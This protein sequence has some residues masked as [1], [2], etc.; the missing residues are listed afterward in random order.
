[1]DFKNAGVMKNGKIYTEDVIPVETKSTTL[2]QIIQKDGVDE[3]YL[4]VD[5][6]NLKKWTILKGAKDIIRKKGTPHEYHFREGAIAF[7]DQLEQC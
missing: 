6:D 5:D 2:N 4:L 3:K 7:P 1:M